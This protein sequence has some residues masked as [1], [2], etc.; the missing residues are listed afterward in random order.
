[1]V[2]KLGRVLPWG[3]RGIAAASVIPVAC[4]LQKAW[5]HEGFE[6]AL[7]SLEEVP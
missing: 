2:P 5:A 3:A 6:R 7:R 4:L 1:L